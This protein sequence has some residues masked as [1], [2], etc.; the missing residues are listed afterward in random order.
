MT[1]DHLPIFAPGTQE[2]TNFP[3][4]GKTGVAR[5]VS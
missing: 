1:A 2:N 3:V 5:A 4:K